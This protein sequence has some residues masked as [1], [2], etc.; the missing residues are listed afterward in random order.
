MVELSVLSAV[1]GYLWYNSI[2]AVCMPIVVFLLLNVQL[3][4]DY[5]DE[6]TTLRIVLRSVWIRLFCSGE[7]LTGCDEGQ[8]PRSKFTAYQL[9]DS[10]IVS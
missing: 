6:D 5:A 10:G 4:S 1:S 8:S 2:K 9:R 7:G 3:V